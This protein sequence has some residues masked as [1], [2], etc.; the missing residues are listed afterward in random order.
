MCS[1]ILLKLLQEKTIYFLFLKLLV[2]REKKLN[3]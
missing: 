1:F 2:Y 3:K